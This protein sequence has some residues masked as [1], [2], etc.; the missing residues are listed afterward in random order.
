MNRR[1]Y[2]SCVATMALTAWCTSLPVLGE[3]YVEGL[4]LVSTVR[5]N[6]TTSDFI[7][8]LK[9]RADSTSYTGALF[10]VTS[11]AAATVVIDGAVNIG[12][13]DATRFVRPVDTFTLRQDRTVPFNPSALQF[14]FAGVAAT[15]SNSAAGVSFGPLQ[16]MEQGGRPYHEGSFA[17]QGDNPVAGA[18]IALAATIF[19]NVTAASYRFI[20]SSG[21]TL[22]QGAL[23]RYPQDL[24]A[25]P[26][27]VSIVSVPLE[28]FRVEIDAIGA[29]SQNSLWRTSLYSPPQAGLEIRPATG[30]LT[31]GQE[32]P[33]VLRIRSSTATGPYSLRLL[34][35]AG[36][37]GPTGPW[38]VTLSPGQTLDVSTM[39]TTPAMGANVTRYTLAA[40]AVAADS[41]QVPASAS[42]SVIVE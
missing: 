39:L 42:L 9:I 33:V 31:K 22:A 40:E 35:P 12:D 15:G 20:S 28:P 26:R 34:L 37:T 32:I 7:Y 14:S 27:F 5:S 30:L 38:V 24:I 17:I 23:S 29:N 1:R 19:G 3:P 36:F 21:Q 2:L 16:F 13:L 8:R 41:T 10:T 25:S 18:N 4:D 6:R 11:T